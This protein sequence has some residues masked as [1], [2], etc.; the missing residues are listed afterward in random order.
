MATLQFPHWSLRMW[1]GFPVDPRKFNLYIVLKA[2]KSH[3]SDI[4]IYN[5]LFRC[6]NNETEEHKGR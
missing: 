2:Y 6:H 1:V 4:N 3:Y 5:T